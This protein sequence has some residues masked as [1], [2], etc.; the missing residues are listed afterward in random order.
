M[1]HAHPSPKCVSCHIACSLGTVPICFPRRKAY[2]LVFEYKLY[3]EL[4]SIHCSTTTVPAS[5]R[6]CPATPT[7]KQF[8]PCQTECPKGCATQTVTETDSSTCLATITSPPTRTRPCPTRTVTVSKPC[9]EDYLGCPP[10]DC[11]AV[12]TTQVPPGPVDGCLVTPVETKLRV[13]KGRCD[14]A[15]GTVWITETPT[16]W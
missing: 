16:A 4:L 9:L 5:N 12:S 6:L 8:L 13:C 15:C 3:I 2:S 1:Q 10:P 11:I 14:A 7:I